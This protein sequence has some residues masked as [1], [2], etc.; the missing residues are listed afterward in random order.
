M[1]IE[2]PDPLAVVEIVLAQELD[3]QSGSRQRRDHL[4]QRPQRAGPPDPSWLTIMGFEAIRRA[5]LL[6]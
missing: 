3:P 5:D 6:I 4:P 2:R 1:A